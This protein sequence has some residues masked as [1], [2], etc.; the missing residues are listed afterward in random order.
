[1]NG[2]YSHSVSESL[3]FCPLNIKILSPKKS[4]SDEPQKNTVVISSKPAATILIR[5]R[6]FVELIPVKESAQLVSSRK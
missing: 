6:K 1:M 3:S 2:F 5:F 4:P